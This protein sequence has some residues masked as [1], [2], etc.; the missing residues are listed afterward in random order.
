MEGT[1]GSGLGVSGRYCLPF[2]CQTIVS[3]SK[4]RILKNLIIISLELYVSPLNLW[5][6]GIIAR[7]QARMKHLG[8][9]QKVRDACSTI[10]ARILRRTN[11][12]SQASAQPVPTPGIKRRI[13]VEIPHATTCLEFKVRFRPTTRNSKRNACRST[14]YSYSG[15]RILGLTLVHARIAG[16]DACRDAM[17]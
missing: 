13:W 3:T 17:N 6:N 8:I 1:P 4:L 14:N 10:R 11:R 9:A 5:L 16:K 7:F 12:Q 15:K 2:P